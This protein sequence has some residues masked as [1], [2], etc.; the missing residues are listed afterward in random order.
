MKKI[1]GCFGFFIGCQVIAVAAMAGTGGVSTATVNKGQLTTS[2]R[3]SYSPADNN[4]RTEGQFS[5]RIMFDYGFTD[6]FSLGLYGQTER[7]A[8]DDPE[9]S[10]VMLDA[11]VE[12][13]EAAKRGFYSGFRVR[14][15]LKDSDKKPDNASLKLI[16]GAPAGKWDF[17]MN[18]ILYYEVGEDGSDGINFETRLQ[19]S[20]Y[21]HP[22]HRIGVESFRDFHLQTHELGP[23]LA[24]AITDTLSYEVGYHVGLTDSTADNTFRFFLTQA[25]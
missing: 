11:K 13:T 21:Y 5:S 12:L 8:D 22:Q 17:R 23:I 4:I 25:F 19:T 6:R 18:Q 16:V 2:L 14:Y 20:Y 1:A 9:F 7:R 10:S 15:T 3:T 24:G